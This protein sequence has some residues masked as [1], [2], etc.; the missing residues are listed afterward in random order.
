MSAPDA[1]NALST[2]NRLGLL[3]DLHGDLEH[4]FIVAR[5]MQARGVGVVIALGDFGVIWPGENW[6]KNLDKIS[7]RLAALGTTL[8]VIDGNHEAFPLLHQFPVGPDGLRRLRHN[9]AHLPR[10]YRTTLS[11]GKT[12]ATFGGANS[13]DRGPRTEGVDWW[14]EESITEANLAALGREPVDIL[15]GH[16][17]PLGLPELDRRMK[18]DRGLWPAEAHTYSADGRRMFHRGFMAVR[19]QVFI[20]GHYHRFYD[21]QVVTFGEG[22]RAFHCRVVTLDQSGPKNIAQAI[23]DVKTLDL[24]FFRRDGVDP[25]PIREAG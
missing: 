21:H 15:L 1:R 13:I 23:L 10:G 7:R 14:P 16:E 22:D 2:T 9:I 20:G 17:A 24:S 18:A 12:L 3:G 8:F 6:P 4:L 19:P 5:T 25:F 11:S